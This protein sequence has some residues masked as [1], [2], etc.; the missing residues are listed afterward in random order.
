MLKAE[1]HVPSLTP[2]AQP[3]QAWPRANT[4]AR[5]CRRA[6]RHLGEQGP[7]DLIRGP[8]GTQPGRTRRGDEAASAG[9][10]AGH[11]ARAGASTRR[12]PAGELERPLGRGQAVGGR[13]RRRGEEGRHA[14][15]RG[16]VED[17]HA[18]AGRRAAQRV[19][20]LRR[21][22]EDPGAA[23]GEPC[24]RAA[25]PGA[26]RTGQTGETGAGQDATRPTWA[27]RVLGTDEL[28]SADV[29]RPSSVWLGTVTLPATFQPTRGGASS[30]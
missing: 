16:G 19:A 3:F 15:P 17:H 25:P 4:P 10:A 9:G 5:R 29:S 8:P 1:P 6:R 27:L 7:R 23:R 22:G 18:A 13:Q 2:G 20:G 21:G 12:V 26:A 11:H 14:V 30:G 24:N 28:E